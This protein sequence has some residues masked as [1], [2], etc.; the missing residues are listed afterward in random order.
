M[1]N[2]KYLKGFANLGYLKVT[3][4]ESG[5][6]TTGN[7]YTAIPG[8]VSCGVNDTR[9]DFEILADDGV[10]DSGSEWKKSSLTITVTE[11]ELETL[12]DIIGSTFSDGVLEEATTDEAPLIA[13]TFS[14][15]QAN[16][17]HRL[18]R[19]YCCK[20]TGY[21]L[22]HA[23][24]GQNKDAQTYELDFDVTPRKLDNNIRGIK[25]VAAGNDLSW[26]RSIT[27]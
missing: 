5:T 26:L 6:Y 8:A 17:G 27:A 9:E 4:D 23:T 1:S 25:D 11:T 2:R 18:F 22:S 24:K 21:K 16:G 12:G 15:L 14:G 7:D 3:A 20:C 19:Y 10:W 13:L